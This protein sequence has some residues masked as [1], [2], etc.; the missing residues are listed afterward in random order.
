MKK[1]SGASKED[2]EDCIKKFNDKTRHER[3]RY[4]SQSSNIYL[5]ILILCLALNVLEMGVRL[6]NYLL[7]W[8]WFLPFPSFG[9]DR[10]NTLVNTEIHRI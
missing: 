6:L 7:L 9:E 1:V 10:F 8:P 4:S 2:L 5:L 3:E